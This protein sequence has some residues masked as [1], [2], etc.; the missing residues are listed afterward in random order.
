MNTS[1]K[2]VRV[3]AVHIIPA[4]LAE[5][6]KLAY[7][8]HQSGQMLEQAD[9]RALAALGVA[10]AAPDTRPVCE[11][12]NIVGCQCL[13]SEEIVAKRAERRAIDA[14]KEREKLDNKERLA[15]HRTPRLWLRPLQPPGR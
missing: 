4:E 7:L 3:S 15:D 10:L 9:D 12:H 5:T 2:K 14:A 13:D 1:S 6:S 8:R 11:A